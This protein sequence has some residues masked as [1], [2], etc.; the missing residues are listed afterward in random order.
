MDYFS[1]ASF[2]MTFWLTFETPLYIYNINM[3]KFNFIIQAII[4]I[5]VFAF[6]EA[7]IAQAP[8][9]L[10]QPFR[11]TPRADE[12]RHIDL[13]GRWEL[14]YMD[15]SILWIDDLKDRQD[16]FETQVPNSV[17]W[18]YYKA[19]KLP[20]P[21]ANKNSVQ[22]RWIEEKA[23]YYRKEVMI[24]LS[25]K[26]S[27]LMLCFDGI[28]YF[29]KVWVN[30]NLIG[31]HEGMFGGPVVD[32]T[33]LVKYGE[34]NRITVEVRAANWGNR[35]TDIESLPRTSVGEYDYSK[36]KG[37]NPRASGKIIKPWVIAGGSGT[38]AFFSLGMWQGARIEILPEV[39]LE[40]PFFMTSKATKDEAVMH[41]SLEIL[42]NKTSL[43]KKLHPWN[44]TQMNHPA[45]KGTPFIPVAGNFTVSVEFLSGNT[46]VLSKE[47]KPALYK[48][49]NWLEE[50][51]VLQ[52]PK[53]WFPNGTG[54]PDLYK[55]NLTLK[56]DGTP[57]DRLS[58][59]YG[60]RT[61][62][63]EPSAGPRTADRWENWQFII[64]G[65]KLFV[66]GM[67][68]TP[69]DVLLDLPEERYRWA[70]EAAKNM[71][72][73]LIRVWGGGL[74]ETDYFYQICNELGI[75]VWQDFPIG[76]QDTPDF[77]QDVWEAQVVQNIFRLRN[78]PCLAVW[79]GGNEFNPYSFGN[80][81]S[82][83][84]IERN[85]DIF[86]KSRLFVRT[87]P[88]D[89]SM[90]SYPD[91][92]PC[93]YNRSYKYEPWVSETGMHSM[94]EANLFYELVDHKELTGLGKMWDKEFYKGHADFIHHF[95]EYG[96]SRVPR[97]LSR[98]SHIDNMSDPTIESVTEA[99][100]V[101]A[102]EF[103]QILSEKMQGNYPVTTGLMPWVFKRHWP[104]IAIQMMDWF[105]QP[106]A[107]YYFLKRTYEPTHV[108]LDLPRLVWASGESV[109]LL[110]KVTHSK[111]INIFGTLSVKIY[112]DTFN[113]LWKNE[114][115][116]KIEQ[117]PS[118][119]QINIGE[120]RIPH[121]YKDHFLFIVA[122][123]TDNNGRQI[124][125]SLY[126]PRV[127][128]QMDDNTLHD[129][130]VNEPIPWITLNNGPWLKPTVAKSQTKL[131]AELVSNQSISAGKSKLNVK[132]SNQ[133]NIPAFMTKLDIA[134]AKRAFC[135][136]D[137]YFW[138]APGESREI[139]IDVLWREP[140]AKSNIVI[141]AEA[142][143]AK[144]QTIK[145]K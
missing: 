67:N 39:H 38:E 82:I 93:W 78:Q 14:S 53:L 115:P 8:A 85:L 40:R 32:I 76:N 90:H 86:D 3:K 28:D 71:G 70:L 84:I 123:L 96:P 77:P 34:E 74:I 135:A 109:Q 27:L 65:K 5:T 49:V 145:L 92:D 106:V 131:K 80:T 94:P 42:A 110:G 60:I 138:L 48:G 104:V 10:L 50:N 130:Y 117:G 121:D 57:I 141:T 88:D 66:K 4:L 33:N 99:T 114:M 73:Q 101:G 15:S 26:G 81:T 87:T 44:N 124:S 105:G 55:V 140:S 129:K 46:A 19:G 91:M 25:A 83:G 98:A 30:D 72:V 63:R 35:A 137:N 134:G 2:A 29:S 37:F 113:P 89:G 112:D 100:Q 62:E 23:W 1:R 31:E 118:V 36:V 43:D 95:T 12:S 13:S 45:E 68:W 41:L 7:V 51:I 61:I 97:M 126:Y 6:N 107:P 22:Y 17:Q 75:M 139:E 108:A 52:N 69:A 9:K 54:D 120:Y 111:E 20:H 133:E 136:T 24:P 125:R 21:Y 128:K 122:E 103:Y 58:L 102:G 47:F 18:S 142:W 11:I 16:P 127:L 116:V 132:V 59:D 144:K 143:N 79:C 119:V 56:K 64:N